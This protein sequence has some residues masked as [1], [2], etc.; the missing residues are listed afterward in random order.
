MTSGGSTAGD[1]RAGGVARGDT[2]TRV[3]A[4]KIFAS[5][6]FPG[7]GGEAGVWTFGTFATAKDDGDIADM[8]DI[9]VKSDIRGMRVKS[10]IG[11]MRDT[12]GHS[13]VAPVFGQGRSR[14]PV[15]VPAYQ[16]WTRLS[17]AKHVKFR[18]DKWRRGW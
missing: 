7:A 14:S 1:H 16:L 11:D 9:G 6:W 13:S 2:C 10:D 17:T 12:G 8:V 3:R 5:P 4:R 18:V 15:L